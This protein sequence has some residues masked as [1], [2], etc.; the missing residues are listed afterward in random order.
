MLNYQIIKYI[1]WCL[2]QVFFK[3]MLYIRKYCSLFSKWFYRQGKCNG[4]KHKLDGKLITWPNIHHLSLDYSDLNTNI[5]SAMIKY[6]LWVKREIFYPTDWC[7]RWHETILWVVNFWSQVFNVYIV[8][9]LAAWV[10]LWNFPKTFW[11]NIELRAKWISN[12]IFK[13]SNVLDE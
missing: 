13:V 12:L 1:P 2:V 9:D 3:Y 8:V 5:L 11:Q 4:C 10:S 6:C 7:D